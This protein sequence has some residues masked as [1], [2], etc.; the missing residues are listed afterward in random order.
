MKKIEQNAINAAVENA[1]DAMDYL[2]RQPEKLDIIRRRLDYCNAEVL[3]VCSRETGEI[4]GE[5]LKS[6]NTIVAFAD[7]YGNVYDFLRKVYG[8]TATSAKH[9]AKFVRYAD[10]KSVMVWR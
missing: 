10:A 5:M 2:A 3:T 8:Y 7:C 4:F 1:M 9:I 6:Y